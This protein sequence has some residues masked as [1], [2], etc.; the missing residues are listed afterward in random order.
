[1]AEQNLEF[2]CPLVVQPS[3]NMHF[4]NAAVCVENVPFLTMLKDNEIPRPFRALLRHIFDGTCFS[5]CQSG[6]DLGVLD[7]GTPIYAD[8]GATRTKSINAIPTQQDFDRIRENCEKMQLPY[9]KT[10]KQKV[11][12]TK[13]LK[14]VY[15]ITI[16]K[17]REIPVY[18]GL[19][20]IMALCMKVAFEL[21]NYSWSYEKMFLLSCKY[22][23]S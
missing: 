3:F 5:A 7:D 2:G 9:E 19:F 8:P 1:M 12:S 4:Q 18:I 17:H 23:C 22:F 20:F 21:L 6:R 11:K 16:E 10:C 13:D 14:I 15:F